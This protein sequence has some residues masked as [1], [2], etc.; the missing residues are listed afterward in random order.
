[1]FL[2]IPNFERIV[3]Q[4][5]S[6]S[7]AIN[8]LQGKKV[9]IEVGVDNPKSAS[10]LQYAIDK[11][12]DSVGGVA[13][14][15][16]EKLI[17]EHA[18]KGKAK[19]AMRAAVNEMVSEL[20]S[21]F[22]GEGFAKN[23]FYND[24]LRERLAGIIRDYGKIGSELVG[25]EK[26]ISEALSGTDFVSAKTDIGKIKRLLCE[27]AAR[28]QILQIVAIIKPALIGKLQ[29]RI[30][31][32]LQQTDNSRKTRILRIFPQEPL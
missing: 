22:D 4:V 3:T 1:M 11:A 32:A 7:N 29:R 28:S 12:A 14:E 19:T 25:D 17:N 31:V 5:S 20:A 18:L 6:L 13:D 21:G 15:I 16:S 24:D 8:G 30:F 27:C 23:I 9:N 2:R 10:Q 26:R